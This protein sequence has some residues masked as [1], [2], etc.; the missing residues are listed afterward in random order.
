MNSLT[1]KQQSIFDY[2]TKVNFPLVSGSGKEISNLHFIDDSEK[3]F[4]SS[5]KIEYFKDIK[6]PKDCPEIILPDN[7]SFQDVA[8]DC[9]KNTGL[10][11][12][13]YDRFVKKEYVLRFSKTYG[14]LIF[15]IRSSFFY[16]VINNTRVVKGI[17]KQRA[18]N[19]WFI[20]ND[21]RK[22]FK[23]TPK[24]NVLIY[25][26]FNSPRYISLKNFNQNDWGSFIG[27]ELRVK[28]LN[29]HL[30]SS[31][32]SNELGNNNIFIPN[33]LSRNRKDLND[34][35]QHIS[36]GPSKRLKV[37]AE[38]DTIKLIEFYKLVDKTEMCKINEFI[39]NYNK[40][41]I[42]SEHRS[43]NIEK[44]GLV[45]EILTDYLCVKLNIKTKAIVPEDNYEMLIHRK[46]TR[47]Q[48]VIIQDYVML[49]ESN[50]L[51][52]D[53][54][55]TSYKKFKELHDAIDLK[56][57]K[58]KIAKIKVNKFYKDISKKYP[59]VLHKHS[60]SMELIVDA[61]RLVEES[62][63]M[64]HCVSTYAS[65]INSGSCA[66]YHVS[67]LDSKE[68]ATLQLSRIGET[69]KCVI[70]QF[71]GLRNNEPSA[72]LKSKLNN[73]LVELKIIDLEKPPISGIDPIGRLRVPFN[74]IAE[75]DIN[76]LF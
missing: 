62:V 49:C 26:N 36:D 22:C 34:I 54:K 20:K 6:Q 60:L 45:R 5:V 61:K 43:E 11:R 50:E 72:N 31:F 76:E 12:Q 65:R 67:D 1:E 17:K 21:L 24:G 19:R 2:I 14:D 9:V 63:K 42:H 52:I 8:N 25:N 51:K 53:M 56:Y 47:S 33:S 7:I 44:Q 40:C 55:A 37:L 38:N 74:E 39:K 18:V 29:T 28:L 15:Y 58:V 73:V 64:I 27:K 23:I 46:N 30:N 71:K 10:Y 68:T 16:Y 13:F 48:F 69:N 57:R 4:S 32:T 70:Y 75:L 66:I 3:F 35:L 41:Y 59:K